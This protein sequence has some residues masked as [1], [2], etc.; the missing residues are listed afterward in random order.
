VALAPLISN[1]A[2]SAC[3]AFVALFAMETNLSS[4]SSVVELMIV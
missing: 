4:T 3:D 1:P 2:P